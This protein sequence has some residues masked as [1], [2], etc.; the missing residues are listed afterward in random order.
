M[1]LKC[2]LRTNAAFISSRFIRVERRLECIRA[3]MALARN[4]DL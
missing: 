3:R 2:C 4:V 1:I